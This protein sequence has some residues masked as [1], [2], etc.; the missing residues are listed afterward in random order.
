MRDRENN[1]PPPLRSSPL[2][3]GDSQ[4]LLAN[5]KQDGTTQCDAIFILYAP[6]KKGGG[7]YSVYSLQFV[8]S[9]I[10]TPS[11]IF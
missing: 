8:F 4:L 2:S 1:P 5:A 9:F 6:P 7:V 3:Q 10:L 11:A